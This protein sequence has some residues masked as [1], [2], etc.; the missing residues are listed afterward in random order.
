MV[1]QIWF[2]FPLIP[3]DSVSANCVLS[4]IT[5]SRIYVGYIDIRHFSI[6]ESAILLANAMMSRRLDYCNFILYGLNNHSAMKPHLVHNALCRF[7]WIGR[8]ILTGSTGS[9]FTVVPQASLLLLSHF[10]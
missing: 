4:A 3:S 6:L 1:C 8:P 10:G 9:L 2:H 7:T 5:T